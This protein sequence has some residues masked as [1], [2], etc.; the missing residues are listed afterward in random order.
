MVIRLGSLAV[1]IGSDAKKI[2]KLTSPNRDALRKEAEEYL[3]LIKEK[4][5]KK[6]KLNY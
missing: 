2:K 5:V 4:Q 1:I 3:K 6:V